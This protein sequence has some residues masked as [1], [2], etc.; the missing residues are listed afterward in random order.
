M[1]Q[2]A[3][4]FFSV[5]THFSPI[6][7]Y[8]IYFQNLPLPVQTIAQL[9]IS[10]NAR[11]QFQINSHFHSDSKIVSKRTAECFHQ[12]AHSQVLS[13]KF[14]LLAKFATL[15]GTWIVLANTKSPLISVRKQ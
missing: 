12:R 10:A 6:F 15:V 11:E 3:T 1:V 8:T 14:L 13:V 2:E 7:K 4:V 5:K 9:L